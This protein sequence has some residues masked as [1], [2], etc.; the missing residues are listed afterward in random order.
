MKSRRKHIYVFGIVFIL[1]VGG[2]SVAVFYRH[3]LPWRAYK[4]PSSG[5]APTLKPGDHIV[6]DQTYYRGHKLTRGDIIVFLYPKDETKTFV[7]RVIGLEGEKLEIK[8]RVV[9]VD[10]LPID[11]PW[12]VHTEDR[13]LSGAVIPRDN[14]GPTI[15]PKGAAFVL[16]DNREHSLD[17]RFWGFLDVKKITGKVFFIYWSEDRERIGQMK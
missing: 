9:Y 5:M 16:G 3:S 12:G 14:Y 15:V 11:D 10:G 7:K 13:I 2:I 1:L 17:G 8:D 6:V 4:I